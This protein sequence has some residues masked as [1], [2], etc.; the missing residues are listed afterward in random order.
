MRHFRFIYRN[1]HFPKEVDIVAPQETQDELKLSKLSE[2][3]QGL[4]KHRVSKPNEWN[5]EIRNVPLSMLIF[6]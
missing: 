5:V 6:L 3:T 2:I 1:K 4:P